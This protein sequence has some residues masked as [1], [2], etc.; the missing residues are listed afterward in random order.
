[1]F[2]SLFNGLS[3]KTI[4]LYN[5]PTPIWRVVTKVPH[6]GQGG[7][8]STWSHNHGRRDHAIQLLHWT[9]EVTMKLRDFCLETSSPR[10][11]RTR[12]VIHL[13]SRILELGECVFGVLTTQT[14]TH[15]VSVWGYQYVHLLDCGNN[16]TGMLQSKHTVYLKY[17]QF[18]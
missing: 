11:L 1:M 10:K 3:L 12:C 16:Y 5:S 15:G 17:I 2:F 18:L 14:H 8:P 13:K 4:A 9:D 7:W 6:P